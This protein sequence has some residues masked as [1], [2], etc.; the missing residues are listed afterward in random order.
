MKSKSILVFFLLAASLTAFCSGAGASPAGVGSQPA[1]P[2]Q[3]A[4][5]ERI[6]DHADIAG[7]VTL[8][9]AVMD[10]IGQ[11]KWFFTHASVGGNML[12]GMSDLHTADSLRYQLTSTSA[13]YDSGGQR[14]P[15]PPVPTL[16]GKIYESSR[17]NPGW[18]AKFTI[19]DNSVR[20]SGWHDGAVGIAMDKLCY[21]DQD[22]DAGDYLDSMQALEDSYP[23]TVFV[24]TTMPLTDD[25]D[26]SNVLRN[27]YNALVRQY[28][29]DHDKY[30]F[31]I[32]D[33]EA[34][35]PGGVPQTFQSGGQTYQKLYS[36]YTSDGGHLNTTG[37]QRVAMGWY[38]MA[39]LIA[40]P[41]DALQ[42]YGSPS[43]QAI[44]L[45][46][47]VDPVPP[48]LSSWRILY[49]GPPG[50]P[51]SPI[52]G[53]DGSSREL[54]LT[55]LANYTPYTVTLNAMQGSTPVLTDT[56][57]VMPTDMLLRL[58]LIRK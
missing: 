56:V 31:D 27:Q 8:P 20:V 53:L 50:S 16:P 14:A 3:P 4:G 45:H 36:G 15:A 32:A 9:Q 57:T 5:D 41:E 49:D 19:F 21:I 38:A 51:A 25:S 46:W 6:I 13:G 10:A 42:L 55:N 26:S 17:G 48:G 24:Y 37:R 54:A 34:H 23:G 30:L 12:S 43:D 44:H 29:R 2:Q 39:A 40:S 7:V 11:Q 1:S 22:A 52:T 35:D 58:P 33:I 18:S 47:D 28:A